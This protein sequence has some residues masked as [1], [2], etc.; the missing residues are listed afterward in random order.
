MEKLN[1]ILNDA[2]PLGDDATGKVLG[3]A[4][5][6]TN[7]DDFL[8]S[9]AAGRIG[10]DAASPAFAADS[11]T[12]I[13]SMSKVV[14]ATCL[15]QLVERG[16]VNLDDD[17]RPRML[18]AHTSG[19]PYDFSNPRALQWSQR[20]DRRP[21]LFPAR[22]R[23][24]ID[25]PLV[26]APDEYWNYG[27]GPD[28][29]GELLALVTGRSLGEYVQE[30]IL[31]PL[32]M[33]DTG[34]YPSRLPHVHD[35]FVPDLARRGGK[36]EL[37]GDSTAVEDWTMEG[38]GG[39]L[40]STARDFATFLQG[41]LAGRLLSEASMEEL[42]RHQLNPKQVKGIEAFTYD[43]GVHGIVA[44]EFPRHARMQ[45]A[46]G[47]MVNVDDVP[48]KRRK[49]SISWSGASGPRWWL[50]RESGIAGVMMLNVIEFDPAANNASAPPSGLLWQKLEEATYGDLLK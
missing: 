34:F 22:S 7:K 47:G 2:V 49:G 3:A 33:R 13:A 19:Y 48:G 43:M 23:A 38:G 11:F 10:L 50:D 5:V 20:P 12:W 46:F 36:L 9:G 44:P 30:R 28:W 45:Q 25:T 41:L 1:A 14:T 4:F 8:Y 31:A 18:L 39:G 27:T 16:L 35:R 21:G 6:V 26:Y 32:G 17:V 37:Q 40:F 29:A 15:L 42:C 24:A